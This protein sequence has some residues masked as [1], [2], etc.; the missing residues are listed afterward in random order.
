M[1]LARALCATQ[2]MILLDEPVSGLDPSAT[3]KIYDLILKLNNIGITIVM[4]SHDIFVATK[5]A[6]KILHLGKENF[7]G[8]VKEYIDSEQGRKYLHSGGNNND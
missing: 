2:R 7:Y 3:E 4:I 8:T 5:Y 6:T 1:L